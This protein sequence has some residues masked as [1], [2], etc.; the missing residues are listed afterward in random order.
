MNINTLTEK[1]KNNEY[2]KTFR[3]LYGENEKEIKRQNERYLKAVESFSKIYPQRDEVRIFSAPGRTEIGGNHTD[4][5]HGC[6]LAA[7]VNLDIIGIVAFHND[8]VIRI[9]SEGYDEFSV[10]LSELE[11]QSGKKTSADIVRG[12]AAKFAG[13]GVKVS[14]FDMYCISDVIGGSGISS[15]AAFETLIGTII[16]ICCNEGRAGAVEIAKIGQYAENVYFDKKSGL[17]DQMVSSVGGLVA[18]DFENTDAPV[19]NS[20]QY[21]FEESGYSLCITDTKGSHAN[22]TDDYVA[23]R[24]E[25]EGV[26]HQFGKEY[27]REVSE[28]EFYE[29][30][31]ELREKCSDRS[32]MRAV[33]FFD[34]NRRAVQ[35]A[36]ALEEGNIEYFMTLVRQSGESSAELLQNLYSCSSPQKQEIPLAIMMSKKFLKNKGAVRVHGGGFAGTIQAFVPLNETEDYINKMDSIFGK[37]SC[38]KLRIRPV[39][40]TEIING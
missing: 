29:G 10:N 9:K 40:G 20:F 4:H 35:E 37:G 1:I 7:A 21:D 36:T 2:I 24:T 39:G 27:L 32:L 6:V 17:M 38:M 19:I 3:Y 23:I 31:A 18:I 26:A 34:E 14:G 12:I 30:F 28:D 22:L 8:G 13:M 15:S 5:Q 25:M 16:D 33:H 11:V